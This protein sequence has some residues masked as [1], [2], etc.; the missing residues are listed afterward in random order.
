[1]SR[2]I[3]QSPRTF[4][5]LA[6]LALAILIA[7]PAPVQA[8]AVWSA[9]AALINAANPGAAPPIGAIGVIG[10]AFVGV[11]PIAGG[12]VLPNG[13]SYTFA[14]TFAEK[15]TPNLV[16][17]TATA[18]MDINITITAGKGNI[19]AISDVM[20]FYSDIFPNTASPIPGY[21]GMAG[22]F[23]QA[24][25]SAQAQLDY[26]GSFGG[27][28]ASA[29]LRTAVVNSPG[30]NVG[31]GTW[32]SLPIPVSTDELT[33]LLAFSL[34]PGES[35]T[36]PFD[37]SDNVS[38]ASYVPEPSSFLLMTLG[39]IPLAVAVQLRRKRSAA[40]EAGQPVRGDAVI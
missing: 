18:L 2:L 39:A 20:G 16:G 11:A 28:P 33:G 31:F 32:V 24:G 26:N 9:D 13:N 14:G 30:A 17:G 37:F 23:S 3:Q 10:N 1:M 22:S 27:L 40:R 12:L 36:L 5:G 34:N 21:V 7:H 35:L 4:R 19:G 15:T 25:G 6:A 29:F 8:A 38:L